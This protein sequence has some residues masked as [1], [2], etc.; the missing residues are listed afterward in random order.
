MKGFELI[1]IAPRSRRHN[2]EPV[3]DS[4][5]SL[6]RSQGITRMTR[7][8]DIEGVGANGHVHS[9]HFFEATDEPQELMFVLDGGETDKLI[10]AVE[11]AELPVFCMRR[12]IDYWQFGAN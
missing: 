2:G 12:Q 7:R 8:D 10:R 3:L 5:A 11:E 4:I 1:F 9:A 6:A